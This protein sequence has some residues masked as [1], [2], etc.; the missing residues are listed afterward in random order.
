MAEASL[1]GGGREAVWVVSALCWRCYPKSDWGAAFDDA[2]GQAARMP[3]I[4]EGVQRK[5]VCVKRLTWGRCRVCGHSPPETAANTPRDWCLPP[6]S[7]RAQ[8]P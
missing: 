6:A 3:M 5:C 4:G 1:T 7:P 2:C 8:Q